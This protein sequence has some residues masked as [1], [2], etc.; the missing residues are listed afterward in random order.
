MIKALSQTSKAK[1]LDLYNTIFLIGHIP[2]AWKL[3]IVF[4]IP[5]TKNTSSIGAYRPILLFPVLSKFI[6]RII[7]TRL[8]WFLENI[9]LIV[10]EQVAFKVNKG[11]DDALL[12]MDYYKAKALSAR[13][14]V[15]VNRL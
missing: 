3:A 13:N 10:K 12:H 1:L 9:N 14:Y 15:T 5:K 6:E 4:P 11:C 8:A 2:H 7:A